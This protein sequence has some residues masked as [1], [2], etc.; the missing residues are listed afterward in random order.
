[1]TWPPLASI[2][3]ATRLPRSTSR[4]AN[5][6][7][8]PSATNRRT[9]ASPMPDAPPLTAAPFPLSLPMLRASP[10][11]SSSRTPALREPDQRVLDAPVDLDALAR[12]TR[13]V[14]IGALAGNADLVD[15]F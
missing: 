10:P 12:Q 8:A 3:A 4:S 9:V 14:A 5:T 7:F 11:V 6:T 15:A 2:S 1:M 13:A